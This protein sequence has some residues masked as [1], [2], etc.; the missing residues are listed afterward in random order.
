VAERPFP[1]AGEACIAAPPAAEE[2]PLVFRSVCR[3]SAALGAALLL[4]A[5]S[6]TP[7]A[8]SADT[9]K[10]AVSNL[11]FG[12]CDFVL[13]PVTGTRAVYRNIQDI[14]DSLGVRVA[15]VIPG[16]VWNIMMEMSGGALRTFTGGIEF[17]P[18]L[19]LLPFDTDLDP[20]LAPIERSSALIDEETPL[21]PVKIGIN[22]VE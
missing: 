16:V 15:Y 10:R 1:A 11:L 7:A 2:V 18:G 6:S 21:M 8:A 22:Y 12:P 14:D 20:L 9:L 5:V 19:F 13:A 4:V 17:I 3:C